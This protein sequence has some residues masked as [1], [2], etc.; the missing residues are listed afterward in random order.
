MNKLKTT[1][2][3]LS[4]SFMGTSLYAEEFCVTTSQELA[5]ALFSAGVNGQSDHIK[6]QE[7]SYIAPPQRW[8]Y[9]ELPTET[10]DLKITGGWSEFF[11]NPCGQNLGGSPLNT[12]LDANMQGRVM[13]IMPSTDTVI[14][15]SGINFVNG[16]L[17]DPGENGGGLRIDSET[18]LNHDVL[19]ERCSFIN[20][21]AFGAG[22]LLVRDA[23][24]VVLRNSFFTL[25]SA[26]S[27]KVA[28]N[29]G[30]TNK[31][32]FYATNNTLLNNEGGL[33]VVAQGTS[34]AFVA[35][36][37][38]WGNDTVVDT[39][40]LT[41]QGNGFKYAYNNNYFT[42]SGIVPNVN[43]GNTFI[44]PLFEAG[45]L[46]ITLSVNSPLVGAGRNS[47]S[48]AP[49]PPPFDL[50]WSIGS[51]GF[52]GN[53]RRQ[54][55]EIDIGAVESPHQMFVEIPIFQNGFEPFE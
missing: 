30:G 8:Q 14:E 9:L 25:N 4:L 55:D 51:T 17:T 6:I 31:Y 27:G 13:D 7:G 3:C 21:S 34:Q 44:E 11:A 2:M 29:I 5:N 45:I 18:D 33:Y 24:K 15:I 19:I 41:F 28:A 47:P 23:N 54:G 36:N 53:P 35:N 12:T 37:L 50:A 16:M 1:L 32:G 48:V 42:R 43:V 20:N 22:G 46:N 26:V 52:D 40:D 49:I 38:M 39:H 10:F